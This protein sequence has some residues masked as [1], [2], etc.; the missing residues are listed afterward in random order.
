MNKTKKST[1]ADVEVADRINALNN[2]F[3]I[4]YPRAK[5]ILQKME[6]IFQQPKM[7]RMPN[8][9]L[10]GET[11]NGKTIL[12]NRFYRQHAPSE[13]AYIEKPTL[14]ILMLQAPPEP[15]EGR[16]YAEI[17]NKLFSDARSRESPEARLQKIRMLLVNLETRMIILDEFQHALAGAGRRR[18]RGGGGG[19]GR[20]GGRGGPGV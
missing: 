17:L 11:N 12:L 15:N 14:P 4:G 8:L 20:G 3:W 5:E 2:P 6:D 18:R 16:L 19:G 13:E 10:I 9:A 7:H 1:T